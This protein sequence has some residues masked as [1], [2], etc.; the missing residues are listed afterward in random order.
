MSVFIAQGE[1]RGLM[2]HLLIQVYCKDGLYN[3]LAGWLGAY[4]P[5]IGVE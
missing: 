1:R 4:K 3:T 2:I 5:P